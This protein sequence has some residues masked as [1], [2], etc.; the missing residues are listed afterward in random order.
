MSQQNPAP[1]GHASAAGATYYPQPLWRLARLSLATFGIYELFWFFRNWR[2][3]KARSGLD[4]SPLRR[5]LL[6]PFFA[7]GLFDRVFALA[8][9]RG[10]TVFRFPGLL[11]GA[12]LVLGFG[13][14]SWDPF[15]LAS[16]AAVLPLLPVAKSA[17][18]YWRLERP[19]AAPARFSRG[20]LAL[21]AVAAP[22]A[23][24]RLMAAFQ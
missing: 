24:L 16:A 1:A 5:S 14:R 4:V 21:L 15:S 13:C 22:L 8:Y 12:Y 19:E 3:L 9:E 6:A 2:W 7:Y 10:C 23:V 18:D 20:D 11:A 17:N